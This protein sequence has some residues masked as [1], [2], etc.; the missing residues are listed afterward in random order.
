MRATWTGHLRFALLNIGVKM[1]SGTATEKQTKLTTLNSKTGNPVGMKK[2]DKVTGKDVDANDIVKGYHT[3]DDKYVQITSDDLE[4]LKKLA[5]KI[6]DVDG[7][8][9]RSEIAPELCD[10][11]NYLGPAD[12]VS[13]PAY[14]LLVRAMEQNDQVAIVKSVV[15]EKDTAYAVFPKKGVLMAIKIRF[16]ENVRL[17]DDVPNVD[18]HAEADADQLKMMKTL[19]KQNTKKSINDFEIEDTYQNGLTAVIEAK[20]Q[21]KEIVKLVEKKTEEVVDIMDALKA[22]IEQSKAS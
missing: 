10:S 16:P 15:R 8:V 7:F 1:Y 14:T 6:M 18:R 21:G 13:K 20:I 19:I 11:P 17:S 5:D 2:Y 22:S 9:S 4:G 12:A 3:G